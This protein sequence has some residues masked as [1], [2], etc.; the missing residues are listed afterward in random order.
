M[1][2]VFLC[3][4]SHKEMFVTTTL[5]TSE[6]SYLD[7]TA[8]SGWAGLQHWK[9]KPVKNKGESIFLQSVYL[10]TKCPQYYGCICEKK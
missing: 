6:Y 10:S 4:A 3:S 8:L 1:Y 5:V 9:M 2:I 7:C